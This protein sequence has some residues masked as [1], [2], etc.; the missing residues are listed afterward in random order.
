MELEQVSAYLAQFDRLTVFG[1]GMATALLIM[2]L[3]AL[4]RGLGRASG[5]RQRLRQIQGDKKQA[6]QELRQLTHDY[7]KR[8]KRSGQDQKAQKGRERTPARAPTK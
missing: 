4:I 5:Y 8:V 1:M 7:L 6:Q 3:G 2:L